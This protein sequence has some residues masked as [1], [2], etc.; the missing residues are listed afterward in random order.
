MGKSAAGL[1]EQE[2]FLGHIVEYMDGDLPSGIKKQVQEYGKKNEAELEKFQKL[3][4]RLQ[5]SLQSLY[6]SEDEVLELR[7]FIRNEEERHNMDELRIEDVGRAEQWSYW[8]RQFSFLTMLVAAG[9]IVVYILTPPQKAEFDS[10]Q[11]L[12]YEA[13][14]FEESDISRLDFPTDSIEDVADFFA[15]NQQLKIKP[16]VLG[17]LPDDWKVEGATVI[18]YDVSMI[19][20]VQYGSA[21]RNEKL[22]HFSYP[23][24]IEALAK[25]ETGI[26]DGFQY[27]AYASDKMNLIVW[28]ES[29][30]LVSMIVGHRAADDLAKI[31]RAGTKK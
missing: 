8:R 23:G 17:Q 1:S 21:S 31:A 4:G 19:S 30:E 2:L 18:D 5:L 7:R 25:S 20:V 29:Y 10:L 22:F 6:L 9:L 14:A 3:R 16:T 27:Q 12:A 13:I 28:Q 26:I 24:K 11:S 15:K